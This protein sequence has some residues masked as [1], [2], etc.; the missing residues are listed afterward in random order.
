MTQVDGTYKP[1][2]AAES[3]SSA[4]RSQHH[5]RN[6]SA[7]DSAAW[8]SAG[9]RW[10][11]GRRPTPSPGTSVRH[12]DFGGNASTL[13]PGIGEG[14]PRA[15]FAAAAGGGGGRGGFVSGVGGAS[16]RY[17]ER[18]EGLPSASSARR[19]RRMESTGSQARSARRRNGGLA[20][21][22]QNGPASSAARS[23]RGG[24]FWSGAPTPVSAATPRSVN[25]L[26][27]HNGNSMGRYRGGGN[28]PDSRGSFRV[29]GP[30]SVGTGVNRGFGGGFFDSMSAGSFS[31]SVGF[32]PQ[33]SRGLG[34]FD[35]AA[36]GTAGGGGGSGGGGRDNAAPAAGLDERTPTFNTR[37]R[38]EGVDVTRGIYSFRDPGSVGS[39][40]GRG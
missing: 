23:R 31:S 34:G 40:G 21:E 38:G 24:Y 2:A 20:D 4:R 13:R 7:W 18:A 8:G 11:G 3:G 29:A 25:S 15:G 16:W 22:Q 27:D 35:T 28:Y 30:P 1:A 19:L 12:A 36:Y 32:F 5:H 6:R 33:S 9:S 14:T 17:G 37:R 39:A 26:A 10:E